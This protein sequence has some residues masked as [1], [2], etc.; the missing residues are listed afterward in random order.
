MVAF[1]ENKSLSK[2]VF[3]KCTRVFYTS[4]S[5]IFDKRIAISDTRFNFKNCRISEAIYALKWTPGLEK[6]DIGIWKFPENILL[7]P[8]KRDE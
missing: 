8:Q 7:F 3:F 6:S 1:Q 2:G 5:T 4:G